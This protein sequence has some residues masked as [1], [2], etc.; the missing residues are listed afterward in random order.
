[1]AHWW[2]TFHLRRAAFLFPPLLPSLDTADQLLQGAADVS[3]VLLDVPLDAKIGLGGDRAPRLAATGTI[4]WVV[5]AS[6]QWVRGVGLSDRGDYVL[7]ARRTRASI[8]AR[9]YRPSTSACDETQGVSA[10]GNY[11]GKRRVRKSSS[12]IVSARVDGQLKLDMAAALFLNHEDAVSWGLPAEFDVWR[13]EYHHSRT[14]VEMSLAS[15]SV[16]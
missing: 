9:T 8:P 5:N 14:L 3:W 16:R 11:E 6:R 1:M 7:V 10:G 15:A 13:G 12:N 2:L 4:L